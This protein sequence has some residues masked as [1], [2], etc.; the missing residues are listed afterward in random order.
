M[1]KDGMK[2]FVDTV[3]GGGVT[4]ISGSHGFSW[5]TSAGIAA[6][7]IGGAALVAGGVMA[8]FAEHENSQVNS[9]VK[10]Y[11]GRKNREYL[12]H[13]DNRKTYAKTADILFGAGGALAALGIVAIVVDRFVVQ[14][15][16]E[17]LYRSQND[18][19]QFFVGGDSVG[20]STSWQF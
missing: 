17:D 14:P 4:S 15:N 1:T 3:F 10:K 6:T 19:F 12:D 13:A 8:G 20:F 7:V 16:S 2:D 11:D 9:L 18:H 5:I